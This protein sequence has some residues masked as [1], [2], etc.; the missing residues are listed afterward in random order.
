[1][2]LIPMRFSAEGRKA[3]TLLISFYSILN[4]FAI[5]KYIFTI[6]E[7]EII[8]NDIKLN[9]AIIDIKITVILV[10]FFYPR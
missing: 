9:L 10:V 1:M 5:K 8:P 2:R 3:Y 7:N 4:C 6:I